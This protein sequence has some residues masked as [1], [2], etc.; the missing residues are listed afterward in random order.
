M[1][2]VK[3]VDDKGGKEYSRIDYGELYFGRKG[4]SIFV[5]GR[6]LSSIIDQGVIGVIDLLVLDIEGY[7]FEALLGLD[8]D[9]H[10]PKFIVVET[11][12]FAQIELYLRKYYEFERNLSH[13]DY[14]FKRLI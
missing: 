4:K 14:L 5:E 11:L 9:R 1:S 10:R 3:N 7:E 13:H 2:L 12:D 8:L 6:T